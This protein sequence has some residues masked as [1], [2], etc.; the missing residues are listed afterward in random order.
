LLLSL[1]LVDW[2]R[3]GVWLGIGLVVYF[4]HGRHHSTL[5][6]GQVSAP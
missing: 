6:K 1:G 2:I 5:A 4:A 3:L